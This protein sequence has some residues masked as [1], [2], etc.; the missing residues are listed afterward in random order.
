[1][2]L[3]AKQEEGI[4]IITE[5]YDAHEKYTVVS[6][7]AGTGKST[8]V[9]FAIEALGIA[10]ERVAYATYTGKAA[11]VLRRKGNSNAKTL[12]KLLYV[13][14]PLPRGGFSR[15]PATHIDYDVVVVDEVSMVPK[16]MIDL[17]MRHQVYI[18]FLGD[19]FQLPMIDKN[20]NHGLLDHPHI[21]L[22][23][24]MRQA[25]ESEIIRLTMKIRNQETINGFKGEE[26][27]I[28]KPNELNTGMLLWADQVICAKNTT[29][30]SLNQ[31]FRQ[32]KGFEGII[33]NGEKV[34]IKRN[35]WNDSNKDGEALVNGATGIIEN[36]FFT[37]RRLPSNIKIPNRDIQVIQAN[38]VPEG[39][40]A[41][42]G[43]QFD[44]R[45]LV[46]EEPC[47]DWRVSYQLGKMSNKIGDIVPRQMTYGYAI[48]C[49][50]A[51]GSEWENVLVVEENFP[52]EK[53]EHARWLYTAATR[54][55][56]R[57]L[58]VRE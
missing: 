39:S 53:V 35:Y 57:L 42:E 37:F 48:T 20:E 17:L 44:K 28:F 31:Q 7:Y 19:P 15:K 2:Q 1:M 26:V 27:K 8:L 29:R 38:F 3:T 55:S 6:G 12:H 43:V 40:A 45:F 52:F 49:H 50:A 23:E 24:I 5:R 30:H 47:L 21:F 25:Q 32:L 11:E 14:I 10:P 13:S 36:P 46:E 34:V 9:K 56:D 22:D 54:A 58:L 41:F 18:I 33:E 51:Q 4:K 16:S